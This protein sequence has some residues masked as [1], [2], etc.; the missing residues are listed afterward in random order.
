MTSTPHVKPRNKG[1][2]TPQVSNLGRFRCAYGIA[3]TPV[4][5][6]S[7]YSRIGIAGKRYALH[8]IIAITFQLPRTPG[9]NTVNHKIRIA[10]GGTNALDNLEWASQAEQNRHSLATN[11]TRKS[12]ALKQSK[13]LYGRKAGTDDEWILYDSSHAAARALKIDQGHVSACCHGKPIA[14]GYEFKFAEATPD[15]P[16][17]E[18]RDVA[19]SKAEVSCFGRIRSSRGVVTTPAVA[20]NG[21]C[22]VQIDGKHRLVHRLV[23][24]SFVGPIPDGEEID[25]RNGDPS[26]NCITNLESVTPAENVRRSRETN[27]NR[28]SCAHQ[29]SK[30]VLGRK[31]GTGEWVRFESVHEAARTLWLNRGHVSTCCNHPNKQKQTSGYEF[32]HADPIEPDVLPGEI[33]CDVV[34]E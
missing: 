3:K 13:P 2:R 34:L 29:L 32:K 23:Y 16:G 31:V 11:P 21:Y 12:N 28:K 10:Q 7:G 30:P 6:R 33:W 22:T 4:A 8:R 20:I 25:H 5:E 14:D 1:L 17:E 27:E 9:Q 26:D 15:L 24:E 18:W 19:G